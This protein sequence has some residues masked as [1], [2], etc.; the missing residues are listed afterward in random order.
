MSHSAETL[1]IRRDG[2]P[3]HFSGVHQNWRDA[4]QKAAHAETY[5]TINGH[6]SEERIS[7]GQN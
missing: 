5:R 3:M 4:L 7:F 1:T 6:S 2:V